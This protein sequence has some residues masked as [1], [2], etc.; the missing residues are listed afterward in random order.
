MK[1]KVL[2]TGASGFVGFHLVHTALN[3]GLDVYAGIRKKSV[4]AHLK[5]LPVEFI[6]LDYGKPDVLNQQLKSGDYHYIIHAAGATRALNQQAYNIANVEGTSNLIAA[7]DHNTL[8]K[9]F[10]YIS[11]LA[12]LGP[13]DH[14]G[15]MITEKSIPHPVT[16]YGKSK[17]LAE[18]TVQ[19]SALPWI[20]IRPT[21]VYGPREKDLLKL[22]KGIISGWD[23]Y[24]GRKEQSLS[25]VHV[26]D[27]AKVAI[28]SLLG[29]IVTEA[30]NI[31]DG[32]SYS[33]YEWADTV[34][35]YT[36]KKS[37]RLH[38][39]YSLIKSISYVLELS[40]AVTGKTPLLNRDKLNELVAVNWG[41]SIEKAAAQ[42]NYHP[43]FNL[44]Q[45]LI[46][47]IDWYKK[48]RWL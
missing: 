22:I 5:K 10:V 41:C 30:F 4:I 7:A 2:I 40:G 27:L 9:K 1:E 29:N 13:Y 34:L 33:R 31:S 25:F 20:I 11:S 36:K 21:A 38:I 23:V 18:R 3:R 48:N 6:E 17:L 16:A 42:L 39:P 26:E 32:M 28:E 14:T 19:Q 44:D 45:G 15:E 35:R 24:I 47:T 43:A 12:A 37:I 46:N 8:L